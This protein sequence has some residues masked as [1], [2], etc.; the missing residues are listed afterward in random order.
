MSH[1]SENREPKAFVEQNKQYDDHH[2]ARYQ[3]PRSGLIGRGQILPC[4]ESGITLGISGAPRLGI[5]SA[6]ANAA[7]RRSLGWQ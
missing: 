7:A 2:D 1:A 3:R 4:L 5:K 6:L